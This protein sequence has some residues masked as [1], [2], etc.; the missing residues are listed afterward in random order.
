MSAPQDFTE[1]LLQ[2]IPD[3]APSRT[4]S[5]ATVAPSVADQVSSASRTTTAEDL[6][7]VAPPG[8][9][10]WGPSQEE[11]DYWGEFI[12][13]FKGGSADALYVLSNATG[14]I[15]NAAAK[16]SERTGDPIVKSV[17][18]VRQW[19]REEAKNLQPDPRDF[20]DPKGLADKIALTLVR[21]A[22]SAI[23]TLAEYGAATALTRSPAAGMA[24]VDALREMDKGPWEMGVA[25][26]R[27]AIFGKAMDLAASA[28]TWTKRTA[29]G[30][31]LGGFQAF[32]SGRSREDILTEA[33]ASGLFTGGL[34]LRRSAKVSE[35]EA[36][37]PHIAARGGKVEDLT[38]PPPAKRVSKTK[39]GITIEE[40]PKGVT[41]FISYL[42]SPEFIFR[43]FPKVFEAVRVA[44]DLE[45]KMRAEISRDVDTAMRSFRAIP[46]EARAEVIKAL[47]SPKFNVL[48]LPPNL[49]PKAK[50]AYVNIRTLLEKY[51]QD[52]VRVKRE[53]GMKVGDDWGIV[54]GYW[55]H[56]FR[57]HWAILADGKPISTGFLKQTRR[58]AARE[59]RR[60]K[61]AHPEQEVK[62]VLF[63]S[64][65]P[66]I[67][68][69]IAKEHFSK[70][71]QKRE[72]NLPGWVDEETALYNYIRSVNRY[73]YISRMEPYL[74]NAR[75]ELVRL[76]GENA[77]EV[78]LFDRYADAVRGRPGK[79]VDAIN[80]WAI[81]AG[82]YIGLDYPNAAQ[83][84]L[85]FIQ[86][87]E[88]VL[89]LGI[90]PV[91][92]MINMFQTMATTLPILGKKYT[93]KG[94]R[95]YVSGKYDW[96]LE[97]LNIRDQAG[98]ADYEHLLDHLRI[99]RPDLPRSISEVPRALMDTAIWGWD[100]T[101]GIALYK[102]QKSEI[103][104]RSIAAIGAYLRA[105]DQGLS[106]NDA[107]RK[108]QDV[109]DRAH[110]HFGPADTP[111][112]FANQ[113]TRTLF[114]FKTFM[115][116]MAE[117]MLGLTKNEKMPG[118]FDSN[119]KELTRFLGVG[120]ASIGAAA[121]PG[122][123]TLS[124]IFDKLTGTN[125]LQD[126]MVDYPVASR[127]ALGAALQVD[128]RTL[129]Y[130]DWPVDPNWVGVTRFTGP[131][132]NDLWNAYQIWQA[133][134]GHERRV[135][136][137]RFW[138]AASPTARTIYDAAQ[139]QIK[140]LRGRTITDDLEMTERIL[141]AMGFKPL[142]EAKLRTEIEA[143]SERQ[144]KIQ[145]MYRDYLDRAWE[146]IQNDDIDELDAVL[147][148]AFEH[149]I[150]IDRRSFK[151]SQ[152]KRV[153]PILDDLRRRYIRRV[154]EREDIP[155]EFRGE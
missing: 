36:A 51:R 57:G 107:I 25:A 131:V 20:A 126:V 37:E 60:W 18:S 90:S 59:A 139:G 135:A 33:I 46:R 11:I 65:R 39:E 79:V 88:A 132:L 47:N 148:E 31:T 155:L 14:V 34:G 26:V 12:N 10:R 38:P 138:R 123:E 118:R 125:M 103:A 8:S 137:R 7:Y 81:E 69:K 110:F 136:W 147:K 55:P 16:L 74:A 130:G 94:V 98:K 85:G 91:R 43:R 29:L 50:E 154:F 99:Y 124:Y 2:S 5:P 100:G 48:N 76:F 83:M 23:P 95:G 73:R 105:R 111:I 144:R 87:L 114:Q 108:A 58:S 52:I 1:L 61:E 40:P 152:R 54:E 149:G 84:A 77:G 86:S 115:L 45:N 93:E 113:F 109:I 104:N 62:I 68:S 17:R 49:S 127:G 153:T 66:N 27:G 24:L 117:F 6:E 143:E 133:P 67:Q 80:R 119:W 56:E 70:F 28:P 42:G 35:A 141:L 22:G 97:R 75:E 150:L 142:R 21:S 78:R 121:I 120:L 122:I 102:F 128:T 151:A 89:K 71:L 146:A 4:E 112:L 41:P 140:T 82:K 53:L 92:P 30:G 129:G 116:K 106:F 101:V 145:S 3:E 72:V 32:I 96:L 13:S 63:D 64:L 134:K 44:K 15:E 19:L 9:R